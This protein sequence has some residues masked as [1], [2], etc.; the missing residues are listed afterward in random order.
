MQIE[1]FQNLCTQFEIL[2]AAG[3]ACSCVDCPCI[4]VSI[5]NKVSLVHAVKAYGRPGDIA[6]LILN[7]GNG[8]TSRPCR[9]V[10]NGR[11]SGTLCTVSRVDADASQ[12]V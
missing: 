3:R 11:S 10:T 6:P 12:D 8:C 4:H 2:A 7:L 9:F 1:Q 5:V